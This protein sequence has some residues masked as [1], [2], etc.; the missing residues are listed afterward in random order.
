MLGREKHFRSY[1]DHSDARMENNVSERALRKLV[2]GRKNWLFIGSKD[3][4]KSTAALLSLVQT[5]RALNIN[6]QDYLEDVF[7]RMLDH[8][9]KKLEEFLPDRWQEIRLQK[10]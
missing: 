4:G 5:C 10:K 8:P 3:A 7:R 6:P 9:A 2:I 1:L